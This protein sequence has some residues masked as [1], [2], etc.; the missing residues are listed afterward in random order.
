[1][2][3]VYFDNFTLILYIMIGIIG[4]VCI[5]LANSN[6][7]V[8]GTGLSR[9]E[10]QFYGLFILI[11][12]SFAVVRQVS[13]EVG[14]T[15][16][17]RYIELFENV[18]KYPGRFADQEQLFLYLNIGVRYLT[19]DYHIYFLLVYGFITFA[20]CYFIRNFCPKD[21]SYIPFLLLIW[22][23]LKSLSSIRSSLAVAL[24][25]VGLAMLK[26]KRIWLSVIFIIATF[27]IHRMSLLYISFLVFYG[28]F[29]KRISQ[30]NGIRI[31]VF[32][33]IYMV[34]G[35]WVATWMQ[36]FVLA[37]QLVLSGSD[38]WYLTQSLNGG[39]LSR[40]PMMFPYLLLLLSVFL[41]G[42]KL[43]NTKVMNYLKIFVFF[44]ILMMIPSLI[45]GMYRANEYLYVARLVMWGVLINIFLH[46]FHP[47]TRP[48]LQIGIFIGFLSWLVFRVYQEYEELSIMPYVFDLF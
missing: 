21:V 26:K 16:A 30:I 31:Y 9:K 17:Q 3:S 46:K 15:D 2:S 29:H 12:T 1:M 24:F 8:A 11:F 13:Y 20:Y 38:E 47:M 42:K 22:P 36:E 14:G 25:L 35:Y 40:W 33:A 45:F 28:L 19:D 37:S 18:L 32:F 41:W 7:T 44:D 5:K 34:L 6:K 48:F 10:F 23:Y 4:G 39:L 27:F 43:P